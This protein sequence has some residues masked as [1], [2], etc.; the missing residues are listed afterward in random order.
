MLTV[1]KHILVFYVFGNG[2]QEGFLHQLSRDC[3]E[4][5]WTIVTQVFFLLP[6]LNLG[7]TFAL[8]QTSGASPSCHDLSKIMESGLSVTSAR[9]LRT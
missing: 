4:A 2:F 9:S 5:A 7:V 1:H 6:F 8:F 3:S